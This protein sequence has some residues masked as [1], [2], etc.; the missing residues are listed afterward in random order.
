MK[1]YNKRGQ[2]VGGLINGTTS[3]VITVIVAFVIIGAIL[4][5]NLLTSGS[6]EENATNNLVG[7]LTSGIDNVSAKIPTILSIAAVVL[8]LGVIVFLVQR[9]RST[10]VGSG[11]SL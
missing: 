7:N 3:L 6:A 1:S 5:A 11:G 10:Q 2:L 4:G 9:A 8:L